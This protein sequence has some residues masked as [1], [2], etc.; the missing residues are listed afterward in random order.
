MQPLSC[1]HWNVRWVLKSGI[2]RHRD[3]AVSANKKCT[4]SST[5]F[6]MCTNYVKLIMS[7]QSPTV[8]G[9]QIKIISLFVARVKL[10]PTTNYQVC[11]YN[12]L[13]IPLCSL[14]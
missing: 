2:V 7:Q 8:T 5:A 11:S 6:F 1:H 10:I 13:P 3:Q 4:H 9:L 12:S 14:P